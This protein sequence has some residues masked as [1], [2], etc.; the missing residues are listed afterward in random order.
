MGADEKQKI[1]DNFKIVLD[2]ETLETV[3]IHMLID[4]LKADNINERI[5]FRKA[6]AAGAGARERDKSKIMVTQL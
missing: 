4:A 2:V 5:N 1:C 6:N 3:D